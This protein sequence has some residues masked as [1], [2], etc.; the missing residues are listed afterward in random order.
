[1]CH[2]GQPIAI[3]VA[4]N[5]HIAKRAAKAVKVEYEELANPIFSIEDAIKVRIF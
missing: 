5:E 4:E 3:V 1:V 2:Y